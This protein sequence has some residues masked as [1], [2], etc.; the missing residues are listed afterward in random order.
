MTPLRRLASLIRKLGPHAAVALFVPGGSVI[1]FFFWAS[2]HRLLPT[3]RAWRALM[4][5]TALGTGLF[6]PS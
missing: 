1:A 5:V 6:F 2:R 4:A 3:V